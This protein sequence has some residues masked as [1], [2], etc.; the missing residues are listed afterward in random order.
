MRGAAEHVVSAGVRA[1]RWLPRRHSN[2]ARASPADNPPLPDTKR[3]GQQ[4]A[5]SRRRLPE[6]TSQALGRR[7][8]SRLTSSSQPL[9]PLGRQ[10]PWKPR[11]L[12]YTEEATWT[13]ASRVGQAL[14]RAGAPQRSGNTTRHLSAL[15]SRVSAT[16]GTRS[17]SR[18][19]ATLS[20]RKLNHGR[21]RAINAELC[22]WL[23]SKSVEGEP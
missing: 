18:E 17:R 16:I 13:N 15:F 6:P 22:A 19:R 21:C 12:T 9:G 11:R 5:E 14:S 4:W 1:G 3:V 8:S 10:R 2:G 7:N 20:G 23:G